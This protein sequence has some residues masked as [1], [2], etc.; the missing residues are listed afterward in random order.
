[1][2]DPARSALLC[3]MTHPLVTRIPHHDPQCQSDP[4]DSDAVRDATLPLLRAHHTLT[5][6]DQDDVV[7]LLSGSSDEALAL[8]QRL[9]EA[10]RKCAEDMIESG[11]PLAVATAEAV[12]RRWDADA[13]C[14]DMGWDH[15][16]QEAA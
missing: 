6:I 16:R 13:V 7:T 9:R 1:M 10:N 12:V 4:L 15:L 8:L 5:D 11:H 2:H 3:A 14:A